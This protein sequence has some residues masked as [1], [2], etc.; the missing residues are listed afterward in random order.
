MVLCHGDACPANFLEP[1]DGT[2]VAIDW[3]Y[4]HVGALGSDL[5]QLVA[6]GLNAGTADAA[7]VDAI[8]SAVFAGMC[9]GLGDEGWEID[10]AAME[11]AWAT[12]LAV[13]AVCSALVMS[14]ADARDVEV[15]RRRAAVGRFGLDLAKRVLSQRSRHD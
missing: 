6:G 2:T 12:H 8:G 9:E 1:G 14:V 11:H 13:R 4:R 3:S 5:A 10:L 15:V 7:E